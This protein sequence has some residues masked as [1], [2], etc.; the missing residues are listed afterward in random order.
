MSRSRRKP[1][2]WITKRWPKKRERSFRKKMKQ[3][4]YDAEI[5]FDPDADFDE[6]HQSHKRSGEDCGTRLGF[7]VPPSEADSTY[8]HEH[9]EEMKRK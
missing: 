9:Y 1:F 5:N 7:D 8:W 3:A 2:E 4:C 6:L